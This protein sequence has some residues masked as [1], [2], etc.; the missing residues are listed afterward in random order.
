MPPDSSAGSL[1]NTASASRLTSSSA[2]DTRRRT[3]ARPSDRI[4]SSE[5]PRETFSNTLMESK[6]AAYWKT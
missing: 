6:S 2:S 5:S 4:S 3:S 1:F